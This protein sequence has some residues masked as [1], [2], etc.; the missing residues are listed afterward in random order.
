MFHY[1]LKILETNGKKVIKWNYLD[2]VGDYVKKKYHLKMSKNGQLT[3][4][5]LI[6]CVFVLIEGP[7]FSVTFEQ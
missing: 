7:F 3:I 4:F 6:R 2:I 5:Q 1:V